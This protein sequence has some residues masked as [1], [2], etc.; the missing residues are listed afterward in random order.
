MTDRQKAR[1]NRNNKICSDFKNLRTKYPDASMERIIANISKPYGLTNCAVR[2][3][4]KK[5]GLC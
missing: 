3:I 1:L 2:V 4:I 5:A